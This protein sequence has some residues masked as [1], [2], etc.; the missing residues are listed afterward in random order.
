MAHMFSSAVG[1]LPREIF[2]LAIKC[3]N[4]RLKKIEGNCREESS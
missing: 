2:N 1:H 3:L 4:K